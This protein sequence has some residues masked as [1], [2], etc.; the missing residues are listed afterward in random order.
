M[1]EE[2]HGVKDL[3]TARSFQFPEIKA[4]QAENQTRINL[5]LASGL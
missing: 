3:P 5:P 4:A 1:L 2:D